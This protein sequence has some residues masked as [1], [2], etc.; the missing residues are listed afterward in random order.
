MAR[1]FPRLHAVPDIH[2]VSKL[3]AGSR[4]DAYWFARLH[5]FVYFMHPASHSRAVGTPDRLQHA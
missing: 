5:L 2:G 3:L 4:G 1:E